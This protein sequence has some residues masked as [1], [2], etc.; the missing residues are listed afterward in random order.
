MDWNVKWKEYNWVHRARHMGKEMEWTWELNGMGMT[1]TGLER[2]L[3]WN[4]T[5]YVGPGTWEWKYNGH[6]N[7]LE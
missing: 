6:G 7:G 2:E 3:G 5:G 1:W 4:V